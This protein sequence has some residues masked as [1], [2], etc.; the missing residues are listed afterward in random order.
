M[1]PSLGRDIDTGT[2]A[3]SSE[4]G[5]GTPLFR[6]EAVLEHRKRHNLEGD[7]VRISPRW[8]NAVYWF[9]ATAF[10]IAVGFALFAS[11][12]EYASGAAVVRTSDH[13]ELTAGV[14][15]VTE[16]VIAHS[17]D[18]VQ[19]G[20]VLVRLNDQ[21][22]RAQ[23]DALQLDF[24]HALIGVL[25]DPE[26][27]AARNAVGL[28]RSQLDLAKSSLGQRI[29]RAPVSGTV[30]DVR[31]R[32]GQ[33]VEPGKPVVSILS[34]NRRYEVVA[35]LPGHYGPLLH[36]GQ[37]LRLRLRGYVHSQIA[38]RIETLSDGVVGA[39]EVRRFLGPEM[40]DALPVQQPSILVRAA[41]PSLTFEADGAKLPY[42]GGL[43]GTAE[44]RVRKERV[45]FSLL[46]WMKSL[47]EKWIG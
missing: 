24:D 30:Y 38:L 13:F 31:V 23:V 10:A 7:L 21:A 34:A 19:S 9:L 6:E 14:S 45:L 29:V 32:P 2:N 17:G 46:P 18:S 22:E 35:L 15:G 16:E 33:L 5:S 20:Q 3:A 8:A 25:R 12:D 42:V 1:E 41:L 40:G 11:V 27:G 36:I 28:V 37:V 4:L 47:R 44:V 39:S 43:Q 26:D